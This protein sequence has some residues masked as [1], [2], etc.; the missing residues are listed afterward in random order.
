MTSAGKVEI[1]TVYGQ[2]PQSGQWLCPMRVLWGL[3][4]REAMSPELE[5]RLCFTATQT[6]SYEATARVVR[7]WGAEADDSTIHRHV[8]EAGAR[9]QAAQ[10][11]RVERALSL[12]TR[13]EVIEEAKAHVGPSEFS[14]VLMMDGWMVR[15]RGPEW[16]WKPPDAEVNRVQWHEM[17]VAILFRADQRAQTQSGRRMILRKF[18][19]ACRAGPYEFGRRVYAEALRRGL[20][21]SKRVYVV[22]DGGVWIWNLVQDRFS[23]VIGVLDFYH[24]SEHLWTV[25]RALYGEGEEARAWVEPL[26]HKLAHGRETEVLAALERLRESGG[27]RGQECNQTIE[28][29]ANYFQSHRDHLH[30]QAIAAQGCPKGSGAVE[31][32]CSQLQDRFKRTGQFWSLPRER[33]LLAL[34]LADCNDDW[35]EIWQLN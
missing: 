6:G 16:G 13:G 9:A 19:V 35:D 22:A 26:L 32:T 18:C 25:A 10:E 31:S 4:A 15:E 29:E 11:K 27:A 2:D 5:E 33:H 28:R 21:Q 34:A 30:Y 3:G 17:K 20:A 23:D 1:R 12:E 14:L 7:R 24:A 8:Q